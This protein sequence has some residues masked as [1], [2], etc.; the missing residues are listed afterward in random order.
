MAGTRFSSATVYSKIAVGVLILVFIL[1]MVGFAIP[2]WSI[3][4][5]ELDMLVDGIEGTYH[6][7]LWQNCSCV[8]TLGSSKCDCVTTET[9]AG[10]VSICHL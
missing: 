4:K 9:F 7:G 5:V 3:L 2:R 8:S 6:V 1:H 10:K